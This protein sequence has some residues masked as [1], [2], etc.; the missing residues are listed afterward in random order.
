M[1]L[2]YLLLKQKVGL[3]EDQVVVLP[4]S[5]ASQQ[6]QLA[7]V[8]GRLT[9]PGLCAYTNVFYGLHDT[10]GFYSREVIL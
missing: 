7:T 3:G 10:D 9:I 4:E 1:F 5:Y 8:V 6:S 2:D